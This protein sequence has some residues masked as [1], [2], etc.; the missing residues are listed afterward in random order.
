MRPETSP[1]CMRYPN[2]WC[3]NSKGMP[4]NVG[5]A[6]VVLAMVLQPWAFVLDIGSGTT[7]GDGVI[8]GADCMPR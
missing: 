4:L 5:D 8:F 1:R 3:F 7:E 2:I 6:G